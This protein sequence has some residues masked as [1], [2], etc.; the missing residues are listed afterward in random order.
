MNLRQVFCTR[1]SSVYSDPRTRAVKWVGLE[2]RADA[3]GGGGGGGGVADHTPF[4]KGGYQPWRWV[5]W[6]FAYISMGIHHVMF[7]SF[8]VYK[9]TLLGCDI[10]LFLSLDSGSQHVR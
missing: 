10:V 6:T 2:M 7:Y 9:G 3:G 1:T 4:R 5:Y 8:H